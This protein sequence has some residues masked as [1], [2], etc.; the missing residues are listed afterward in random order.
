MPRD[1][2]IENSVVEEEPKEEEEEEEEDINDSQVLYRVHSKNRRNKIRN[3]N[4][5][6]S[7]N[8]ASS[9]SLIISNELAETNE[10]GSE[11][12][13]NNKKSDVSSKR[14]LQSRNSVVEEVT[15]EPIMISETVVDDDSIN[16]ISLE[17]KKELIDKN[18]EL[19]VLPQSSGVRK[20]KSSKKSKSKKSSN[21]TKASQKEKDEL[22]EENDNSFITREADDLDIS[23]IQK[24][25]VENEEQ[26]GQLI[27]PEKSNFVQYIL[28]LIFYL[29]GLLKIFQRFQNKK[30]NKAIE[31]VKTREVEADEKQNFRVAENKKSN[32]RLV[33]ND[34]PNFRLNQD[35]KQNF[36]LLKS[37]D[38][39]RQLEQNKH[40]IVNDIK[41]I[42]NNK[43]INLN[44]KEKL[45]VVKEILNESDIKEDKIIKGDN[46]KTIIRTV[47]SPFLIYII[48]K[49][50]VSLPDKSEFIELTFDQ[51]NIAEEQIPIFLLFVNGIFVLLLKGMVESVNYIKSRF[52]ISDESDE[53]NKYIERAYNLNRILIT[54]LILY[55]IAIF[56]ASV[57]SNADV[58]LV[59]QLSV[60]FT[61][62][63]IPYAVLVML[64]RHHYLPLPQGALLYIYL[65]GCVPIRLINRGELYEKII[66][67]P[68]TLREGF[69][70]IYLTPSELYE[71]LLALPSRIREIRQNTI[72]Y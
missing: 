25:D 26:G 18:N 14:K 30:T 32:F 40:E 55:A 47:L 3:R 49:G 65:S 15:V 69:S 61:I 39:P 20:R 52:S 38:R 36:R 16:E 13:V 58:S 70:S 10:D 44:D 43:D 62:L 57:N 64:D 35:K 72:H 59:S 48:G 46:T 54:N 21:K 66:T 33:E 11:T 12:Y 27:K 50:L 5:N 60:L 7:F 24:V 41:T 56:G 17:N 67:L 42:V 68:D 45:N 9:K 2:V 23:E 63:S 53:V 28:G 51:F 71:K 1:A 29:I 19:I 31:D 22:N 6:R 34:E 4:R 8:E 37:K